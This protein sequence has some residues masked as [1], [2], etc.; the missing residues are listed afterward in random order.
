MLTSAARD[1]HAVPRCAE[2]KQEAGCEPQR[3]FH[4]PNPALK[5]LEMIKFLT[6]FR[7]K[8]GIW[9]FQIVSPSGC[10]VVSFVPYPYGNIFSHLFTPLICLRPSKSGIVLGFSLAYIVLNINGPKM[11]LARSIQLI[12]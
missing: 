11:T 6:G 9:T 10:Q 4:S 5:H 1:P 8:L 7:L 3:G 12:I 2:D